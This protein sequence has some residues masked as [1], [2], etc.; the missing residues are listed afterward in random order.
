MQGFYFL[1]DCLSAPAA[2]PSVSFSSLT[3]VCLSSLLPRL[4][5]PSHKPLIRFSCLTFDGCKVEFDEAM[6]GLGLQREG[7]Y[8][9][10]EHI[11]GEMHVIFQVFS[12]LMA[13]WIDKLLTAI[14]KLI[15]FQREG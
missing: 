2:S 14:I 10:N 1:N 5:L 3:P 6:Y 12:S 13:G 9:Q 15:D 4:T 7:L 11:Q 8:K